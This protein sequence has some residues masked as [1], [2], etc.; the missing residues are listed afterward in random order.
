[1]DTDKYKTLAEQ[2][3]ALDALHK[4]KDKT[5][6]KMLRLCLDVLEQPASDGVLH[7][8][9]EDA[10]RVKRRRENRKQLPEALR[11]LITVLEKQK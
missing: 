7:Q 3:R 8:R 1:M 10:A 2:S 4:E 11:T 5:I 9:P 6:A